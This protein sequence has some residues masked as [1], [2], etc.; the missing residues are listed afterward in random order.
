[1]YVCMYV[2]I[3]IY[4]YIQYIHTHIYIYIYYSYYY[5]YYII[6]AFVKIVTRWSQ[7]KY[8]DIF[9]P[10]V[11]FIQTIINIFAFRYRGTLPVEY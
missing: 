6:V 9:P 11:C 3:Y 5:N 4:I 7:N 10:V 8:S 1:M 2:Y